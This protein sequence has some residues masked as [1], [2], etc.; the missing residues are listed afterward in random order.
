MFCAQMR[1][2]ENTVRIIVAIILFMIILFE[3]YSVSS[4]VNVSLL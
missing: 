3:D 2:A 1:V 4:L